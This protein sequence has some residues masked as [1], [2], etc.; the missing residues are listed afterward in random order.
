[1]LQTYNTL[2]DAGWQMNHI[3]TMDFIGFMKVRA[4]K[5][6]REQIKKAPKKRYI[7]EVWPGLHP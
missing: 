2:L 1:V 5:A 3:D 7:D 6:K 4:W